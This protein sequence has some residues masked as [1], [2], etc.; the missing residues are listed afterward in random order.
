M[1]RVLVV[2]LSQLNDAIAIHRP[3]HVVTLLSPESMIP[4]AQGIPA[5]R[6]LRLGV[7]DIADPSEGSDPPCPS[8]IE[9]LLRFTRAWDTQAPLLIHCWAGISRS[10]ACAFTVLCDRLGR[11]REIAIARAMRRR[12]PHAAP[13]RLLVRHADA[14]LNRDG[15]MIAALNSM[16]TPLAVGEGVLSDFPLANL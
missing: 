1:P 7:N 12:A 10:M 15:R 5:E 14:L 4:T 8:H 3:S 6:H 16:G 9:Q 2:S 13:N 11:D